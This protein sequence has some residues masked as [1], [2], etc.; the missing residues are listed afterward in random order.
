MPT[1]TANDDIPPGWSA[2]PSRWTKRLPLVALAAIGCGIALYLALY[3]WHVFAQVWEPFFGNGAERVLHSSLSRLLPIPD[4]ALGVIGY[5]L[6]V[7]GGLIGGR[8]RWQTMPWIV[9]AFGLTGCG[10]GL[11]SM[12][13]VIF[14][15]VLFDGWCT[16]C[17]ASAAISIN[18]VGPALD[19]VLATLQYLQWEHARGHSLWHVFWGLDDPYPAGIRAGTTSA[20][21]ER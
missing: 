1:A 18:L 7:A 9:L 4:A 2:N 17:L 16:L 12:L 20:V 15:P 19:E 5:L 13:L 10:L 6:D 8:R 11:V 21:R 14:Q 3:Q